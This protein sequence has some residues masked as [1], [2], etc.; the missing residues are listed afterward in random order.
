MDEGTRRSP[1]ELEFPFS[2]LMGWEIRHLIG[3]RRRAWKW[4]WGLTA[5]IV[6]AAAWGVAALP[7]QE[8]MPAWLGHRG[9]AVLLLTTP[10]RD[11]VA[12]LGQM[13]FGYTLLRFIVDFLIA[14]A[15]IALPAMA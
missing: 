4:V 7:Q 14:S 3:Q 12:R 9:A 13:S 2:R 6:G 11:P 8:A 15:R 1:R 5:V 10:L